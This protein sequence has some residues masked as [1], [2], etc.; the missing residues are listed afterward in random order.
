M[1]WAFRQRNYAEP[2]ILRPFIDSLIT[3]GALPEPADGYNVGNLVGGDEWTWP[4]LFELTETEQAAL[5]NSTA[6]AVAT[7]K[8]PAT[9]ALPLTLGE[10][11][12]ML[13]YPEERPEEETGEEEG[14]ET[15]QPEEAPEEEAAPPFP[16]EIVAETVRSNYQSGAIS[17]DLYRDW[18][19][20]EMEA[21]SDVR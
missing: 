16:E 15:Q 17:P 6:T 5:A 7:L 8:D 21:I 1:R 3:A 2:F 20:M 9:Q 12:Q 18:L 19:S 4:S 14:T 11:R 13:G 10:I